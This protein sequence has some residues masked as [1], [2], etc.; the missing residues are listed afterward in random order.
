METALIKKMA[1]F[2]E[3]KQLSLVSGPW[4][5]IRSSCAHLLPGLSRSGRVFIPPQDKTHP[6]TCFLDEHYRHSEASSPTDLGFYSFETGRLT[7]LSYYFSITHCHIVTNFLTWQF[8]HTNEHKVQ[9]DWRKLKST[10]MSNQELQTNLKERSQSSKDQSVEI[11]RPWF[12][13]RNRFKKSSNWVS[14]QL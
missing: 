7:A 10:L 3:N 9:K 2:T 12:T 13:I 8:A 5:S 6:L 11:V 1:L 14:N 4:H